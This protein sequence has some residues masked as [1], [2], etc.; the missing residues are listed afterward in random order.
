M[1]K[2]KKFV[3]KI[4]NLFMAITYAESGCH[5]H[6]MEILEEEQKKIYKRLTQTPVSQ[7]KIVSGYEYLKK[8]RDKLNP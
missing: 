1:G 6:A 2:I 4:E 3:K 8:K 7:K 5:E